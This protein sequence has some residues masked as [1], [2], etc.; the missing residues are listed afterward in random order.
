MLLNS[1]VVHTFYSFPDNN[2]NIFQSYKSYI[3]RAF[4]ALYMMPTTTFYVIT[5]MLDFELKLLLS[6]K[7]GSN[8]SNH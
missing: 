6:L 7:P 8:K 3:S 5:P 2:N 4:N 1:Y